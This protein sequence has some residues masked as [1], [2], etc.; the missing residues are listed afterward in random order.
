MLR[1]APAILLPLALSAASRYVTL[2]GY[3]IHYESFG[4][5]REALVFIHGWTCD[6]TFWSGQAPVYEK[7]RSLLVDLLGHGR[8]DKPD[9]PYTMD[10]FARAVDAVMRDAGVERATLVGHSMGTPVALTFLRLYPQKASGLV[11]VDAFIPLPPKDDAER[12]KAAAGFTARAKA[13]RA[14]EYQVPMRQAID[15]MFTPQ[16]PAALQEQI[17]SQML[18]TPQHVAASAM[19]GMGAMTDM[20][21]QGFHFPV[22][23]LVV[24]AKRPN[25]GGPAYE[26]YLRTLFPALRSYQEW[27]GAGHFLMMEQPTRFNT[28]LVDFLSR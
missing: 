15:S 26:S 24:Q 3:R 20:Y 11:I 21:A 4:S 22:P 17:R 18:S 16:T 9:L 8:S 28:A 7:R 6:L 12:E 13:L 2:D 1:L 23:T 19:E 14:P 27:E 10:L 25:R 5:G